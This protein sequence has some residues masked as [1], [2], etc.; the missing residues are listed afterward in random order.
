ML[1]A[2]VRALERAGYQAIAVLEQGDEFDELDRRA[3]ADASLVI[4]PEARIR[5]VYVVRLSV[6]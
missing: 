4:T 3:R 5:G 2:T 1:S 6:R